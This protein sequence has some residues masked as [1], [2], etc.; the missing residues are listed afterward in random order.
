MASGTEMSV[1]MLEMM[2]PTTK[3]SKYEMRNMGVLLSR[4]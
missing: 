1:V 4:E 2:T 3:A